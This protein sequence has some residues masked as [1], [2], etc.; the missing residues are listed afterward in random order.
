MSRTTP[1]RPVDV[2]A[3][4]PQLAALARTATRLHPRPGTPTPHHS[5]VGGPLLWPAD[6]PWPHCTGPHDWDGFNEA[7]S[8]DDIRLQR[9]IRASI[10]ARRASGT[11]P[12]HHTPDERALEERISTGRPWPEGPVAMLPVAQLFARDVPLLR[13]PEDTDT[14]LLQV[15]WCPFD[16][17]DHPRTATYWRSSPAISNT[18]SSPPA[19]DA[20]QFPGYLPDPCLLTPEEVTEYP[21]PLELSTDDQQQLKDAARWRQAGPGWDEA[22]APAA[23]E[24]YRNQLSTSPGWKAGGWTRWGLTDPKP[25]RCS[26]CRSDMY[27][28]L[29][30]A[31]LE[32]SSATASWI[33]T[34]DQ[35]TVAPSPYSQPSNPTL[36]DLAR[37][38][39]LQLYMCPVSAEHPHLELIQ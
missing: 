7:L 25:R 13:A 5:S 16:H 24:F 37:G 35:A 34:E 10:A 29:T 1:P 6:Q 20:L 12:P 9:D 39:D 2:T 15:L 22:Y 21:N 31:S 38:Y 30:I 3:V 26:T 14:D 32:W 27:P 28:L 17:P 18:L 33:P 8:P 23:D 4:F 19:P 11:H 36:L